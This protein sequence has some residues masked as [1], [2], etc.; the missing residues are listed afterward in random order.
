MHSVFSL[1]V[2]VCYWTIRSDN[3]HPC[4]IFRSALSWLLP[5]GLISI[6]SIKLSAM[7]VLARATMK[8]AANCDTQCELQNS[9]NHQTAERE[10]RCWGFFLTARLFQCFLIPPKVGLRVFFVIPFRLQQLFVVVDRSR[11]VCIYGAC[12][13]FFFELAI[14]DESEGC[15]C[16]GASY[17]RPW[18]CLFCFHASE[19]AMKAAS[20]GIYIHTRVRFF[21]LSDIFIYLCVYVWM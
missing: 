20:E 4:W 14:Q 8:D 18:M 17:F 1:G 12:S 21:T 10:R 13:L 19:K 3:K 16:R 6:I 7:D 9:V 5:I 11:S 2:F 15:L